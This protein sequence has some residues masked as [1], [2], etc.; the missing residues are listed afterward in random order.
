MFSEQTSH[1][2]LLQKRCLL[3]IILSL[4]LFTCEKDL[5]PLISN[6]LTYGILS[7]MVTDGVS[8]LPIPGAIVQAVHNQV[9]DTCD[10]MGHFQFDSLNLGPDT[11]IVT[12]EGYGRKNSTIVV[13]PGA[14]HVVVE[15]NCDPTV[16]MDTTRTY[17]YYYHNQPLYLTIA[18]DLLAVEFDSL[19]TV[20]EIDTILNKY[21]L[22]K[23][24]RIARKI[25]FLKVPFGKRAE[26]YFTFYGM[27]TNCGFGNQQVVQYAT[28]V[29]WANPGID[30]SLILLTDEFIIEI[31]TLVTTIERINKINWRHKVEILKQYPYNKNIYI[32]KVTKQSDLC[33]L[34]MANLYQDSSYVIWAEPNF[35]GMTPWP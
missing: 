19:L 28:P 6:R 24:G 29:F 1:P 11:L 16:F 17:F 4:L 7:G 30:S 12:A 31:D 14:Q 26:E 21:R 9:V 13:A 33:A 25:T 8:E 32:L 22:Y 20:Q 2:L 34:D 18:S 3:A 27:N 5:T 35:F 15:L 10:Q 23:I